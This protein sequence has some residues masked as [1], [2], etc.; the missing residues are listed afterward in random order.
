MVT[1]FPFLLT[2]CLG[3]ELIDCT[4]SYVLCYFPKWL[5]HFTFSQQY[6]KWSSFS[7]SSSVFGVVIISYFGHVG[8]IWWCL[9][10]VLFA[11]PRG[12]FKWSI[13]SRVMRHL[14]ILIGERSVCI[15][16]KFL[17]KLSIFYGSVLRV[18][19]VF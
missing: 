3:V 18:H 14:H 8:I 9:P 13:I 2:I 5:Y 16:A 17:I 7:P 11:L 4:V 1:L 15:F 10:G 19:Y 6:I 12:L